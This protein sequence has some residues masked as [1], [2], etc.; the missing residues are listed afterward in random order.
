MKKSLLLCICAVFPVF[1][2]E[3]PEPGLLFHATFD[4]YN[5]TADFAKG[6]PKSTSFKN[7]DLQ[8]RMFPGIKGKG[9]SLRLQNEFCAWHMPGNFNTV[10][11]TVSVWVSPQTWKMAEKKFQIFFEA[12]Q[13]DF[14]LILYKYSDPPYLTAYL[15]SGKKNYAVN[16]RALDADWTTGRW[17]NLTAVW[18]KNELKLYV[19]GRLPARYSPPGI[20]PAYPDMKFGKAPDFPPPAANGFIALGNLF[21]GFRVDKKDATALD[22]LKIYDRCLSPLEIRTEYEKYFPSGFGQTSIP[23]VM[24]I[25]KTADAP[26][27]DGIINEDEWKNAVKVPLFKAYKTENHLAP[28]QTWLRMKTDDKNL[29]L[30]F[31]TDLKN[32][33]RNFTRND[34]NIYSDDIFEFFIEDAQKQEL[35]FCVNGNGALFDAKNGDRSW[36]SGAVSKAKIN[37]T[38][39]WSAELAIPL[40]ALGNPKAGESRHANFWTLNFAKMPH[41]YWSWHGSPESRTGNGRILFSDTDEFTGIEHLGN[42]YSGQLELLVNGNGKTPVT[43]LY[44]TEDRTVRFDGNA[45]NRKWKTSLPVGKQRIYVEQKDVKGNPRFLY[46]FFYSVN[47][48]VA[49]TYQAYPLRKFIEVKVDINNAG[50][51]ILK[52]IGQLKGTLELVSPAGKSVSTKNFSPQ[53]IATVSLPLTEKLNEGTYTIR[54]EITDGQKILKQAVPFR[55]PPQEPYLLKVADDHTVPSPWIKIQDAGN[56]TFRILDREYGFNGSPFPARMNSRGT[57]VISSQPTLSVNGKPVAWN[58]FNAA[59]RFDDYIVLTGKG[60]TEKL[61]FQWRSELW[62]DGL[63]KLD[64]SMKP[65]VETRINSMTLHW[66][67]PAESGRYF[68]Q[69]NK[70]YV[71]IPWKNNTITTPLNIQEASWLT[72][73]ETGMMWLPLNT[74]NWVISPKKAPFRLKRDTKNISVTLNLIGKS[75][76]LTKKADYSIAFMATP[77]RRPP[78]NFRSL[79]IGSYLDNRYQNIQVCGWESFN[80]K[81]REDDMIALTHIMRDPAGFH[82]KWIKPYGLKGVKLYPYAQPGGISQYDAEFDYWLPTWKRTPGY[83]QPMTKMGVLTQTYLCCGRGIADLMAYRTD[84]LFRDFPELGGIYYDICDVKTCGNTAHGCGGTDAFGKPYLSSTAMQLRHYLMRIYKVA[85]KHGKRVFNHAHN[86]F[87]PVAHN[88]SDI[89]YPGENEV[90][91]YGMNPDH[92]Y[93]EAPLNE[94]Q[95]A[96][97]PQIRGTAVIRCSQVTRVLSFMKKLAPR[98][99]ELSS[100]EISERSLVSA[101]L[102]DFS[103]DSDWINHGVIQ[104]WWGIKEKLNFDKAKFHGYWFDNA[105]RSASEK[106]YVSWYELEAPSEYSRLLVIGNL[107]RSPQKAALAL[108]LKE[109]G[110]EEKTPEMKELWSNRKISAGELNSHIIP[111]NHF[112]LIGIR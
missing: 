107:G 80:S 79:N 71:T 49:L 97:N 81:P 35:W 109:L 82:E 31:S 50:S 4:S 46:E 18:N 42:I 3:A 111:G 40:S 17:H 20:M 108:N 66:K 10:Q 6:D 51:A 28:S 48:P 86:Y 7:P 62:F 84:K 93:C 96:W 99:K 53:S 94:Y 83:I 27:M 21:N 25:P 90:W 5:V 70:E 30:G 24:T 100:P 45:A 112:L 95:C 9:N 76:L 89:W 8:F 69:R 36:N 47:F 63:Y 26:A 55:V 15:Q 52:Q 72:G 101:L 58:D 110:L 98:R 56:N 32:T 19:D 23:P 87:N 104:K 11:G 22:E 1:A 68:M 77:A 78:E 105:A 67:V 92:Y 39:G 34:Q 88:F 14:R 73:I 38:Q 12:R 61:T 75:S 37:G 13:N 65:E 74:A 59:E 44:E 106:V 60:S 43:A 91:L 64:F 85:H 29:Y 16:A 103:T 2:E 41:C 54:V 57:E 33:R 102:H